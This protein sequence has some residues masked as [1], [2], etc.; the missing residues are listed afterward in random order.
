MNGFDNG[1]VR[2]VPERFTEE[3]DDRLMHSI[4]TNY[5]RE[6]KNGD[7]LTGH[8]FLSKSDARALANEVVA[9]HKNADRNALAD[10]GMD[11][12]DLEAPDGNR[13]E[14][15]WNHFD[16]NKDGLIPA[17]EGPQF[18]RMILG[19]ALDIDLQ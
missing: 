6:V 9:N 1:Y 16:V 17:E 14:D 11:S 12:G 5:A 13:F 7:A 15:S 10:S 3:R 2:E 4:I 8:L 19:N 18:V